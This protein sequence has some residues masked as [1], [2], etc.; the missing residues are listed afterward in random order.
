MT[1]NAYKNLSIIGYDSV[2]FVSLDLDRSKDFYVDKLDMAIT[3]KTT[4]EFEEK[5][6]YKGL[7]FSARNINMEVVESTSPRCFG[8]C[9][10]YIVMIS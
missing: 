4:P 7:V 6:G 3:A 10:L 8:A 9:A 2:R 1:D 5:H